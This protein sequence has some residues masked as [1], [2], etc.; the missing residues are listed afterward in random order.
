MSTAVK[1]GKK[2]SQ[3][4][5]NKESNKANNKAGKKVDNITYLKEGVTG[6]QFN[7]AKR[8][9]NNA[10]K[11]NRATFS[12]CLNDA[13]AMDKGF[14]DAMQISKTGLKKLLRPDNVLAHA[15]DSDL[16]RFVNSL[17]K[18]GYIKFNVWG[19]LGMVK[20]ELA[21]ADKNELA[22]SFFAALK[23]KDVDAILD[24]TSKIKA[25]QLAKDIAR[26]KAKLSEAE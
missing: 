3:K 12:R 11:E 19:V 21:K 13:V 14:F 24:A 7:T 6:K 25:I 8:D 5:A 23:S 15:T 2:V 9:T 18:L 17:D 10:V 4:G 1:T 16:N 26:E 20:K 22:V